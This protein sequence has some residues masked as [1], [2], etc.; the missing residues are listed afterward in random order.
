MY[1]ECTYSINMNNSNNTNS[2]DYE[3]NLNEL[4]NTSIGDDSR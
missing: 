4:G 1:I 2:I 3:S